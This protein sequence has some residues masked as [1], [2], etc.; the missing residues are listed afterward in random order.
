[1]KKLSYIFF[2][3][4]CVNFTLAQETEKIK[5]PFTIPELKIKFNEDGSRFVKFN[6]TAQI[7]NRYN[8]SNPGTLTENVFTN[9]TFDIGIRRLRLWAVAKPL[10]WLMIA[11]QFGIN[12]FNSQSARKA[13]DF[14]H[15][16]YVE[17][18]PIKKKLSIGTGLCAWS[19]HA[20]YS[21][22]SI[23]SILTYD[24]PL[25]QQ[26][27]NDVNDQFLRTLSIYAKGQIAKFDYRIALSDPLSLSG[28]KY[29][30]HTLGSD[31]I[32]NN[33]GS[34]LIT[35]AYVKYQIFDE[36]NNLMPYATGSYLGTK[37]VLAF[38][39]GMEAQPRATVNL[40]T[41][42]DTVYHSMILVTADVFMDMPI[43]KTKNDDLTYYGAYSYTDFGPNY[44]RN[45]GVMNPSTAV[46]TLNSSF[47][48]A[49][50]A[51]PLIGSG[52][53]I[54]NQIGYKL[55]SRLF[56][57]QG[58]TLQPYVDVQASKFEKLNDWMTCYNAGVN[59]LLV[60]HKAKLSLNYQNRP[61][62]STT[63]FTK[64]KRNSAVILQWQIAI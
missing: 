58:I 25:Y 55:P 27:T 18:T 30:T 60:G 9:A 2:C 41:L 6:M 64:T 49:G 32:Y 39:I 28:T 13:G 63:D 52:H 54:Y 40:N 38:G 23:G 26:S 34:K 33:Q 5:E 21:T 47:N 15:D 45:V 11:T 44:V 19:G 51:Y 37:K 62:F 48:G 8:Q 20:R 4:L 10:D 53:T 12:N 3:I 36:E 24:A 46:N 59:L 17:L 56:G 35:S 61:I 29:D 50:N 43:N 31:A 16:A 42:G 57:Q 7:W 14:F 22:P 1:M